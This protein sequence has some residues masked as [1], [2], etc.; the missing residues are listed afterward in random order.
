METTDSPDVA[1]AK[2]LVDHA[3]LGGFT[4]RRIAPGVDSPL[5]GHR[6][7]D[8]WVDL[9]HIEGFS[10]DCFAWR[11]RASSLIVSPGALVQRQVEGGALDVLS[12]VLTW[13]STSCSGH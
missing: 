6:V 3:K 11:K 2:R 10:R 7:G 12:E 8:G 9:V 13:E 5:V 4:F 1:F